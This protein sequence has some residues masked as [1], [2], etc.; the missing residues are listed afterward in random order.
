MKKNAKFE[1][2]FC[3]SFSQVSRYSLT[4]LLSVVFL[5]DA[6]GATS[7]S[8][9]LQIRQQMQ[10]D[11]QK[12]IDAAVEQGYTDSF[13][14][15]IAKKVSANVKIAQS[16]D[17]KPQNTNPAPS[18]AEAKIKPLWDKAHQLLKEGDQL[19]NQ[20]SAAALR[21]AITKF[22]EALKIW[23]LPEVRAAKPQEAPFGEAV[24]LSLIGSTYTTLTENT[25]AVGYLEQAL[26]IV[27][28]S[29]QS[30]AREWKALIL[31]SLGIVY[32]QLGEKQKAI[33]A[34]NQAQ[35]LYHA[36]KQPKKE[37]DVL[38]SIAVVYK[39]FG[40]PK[41]ERDFLERAL[42][43]QKANDDLPGQAKTLGSIAV[44]YDL[45]GETNK[46]LDYYQQ[47]LKIYSQTK[48][49]FGQAETFANI[50][51]AYSFRG[52]RSSAEKYF[53]QALELQKTN[54][55][56]IEQDTTNPF[57]RINFF[58][59]Q[60]SILSSIATGYSTLGDIQQQ[61][62]YLNKAR[63]I[64]HQLGN[65][66][67]EANFIFRIGNKYSLLGETQ[68]A[69]ENLNQ[70]LKL[71]RDIHDYQGEAE[72]LVSI[73]SVHTKST[74]FQQ[75]LDILFNQALK[76]SKRHQNP[77]L[78]SKTLYEIAKVYKNLGAYDLSIDKYKEVLKIYQQSIPSFI[79]TGFYGIGTV[80]LELCLYQKKA[81][82]CHQALKYFEDT[83][84]YAGEGYFTKNYILFSTAKA[85]ELLKE[86]PKAIAKAKQALELSRK[87]NIKEAESYALRALSTAYEGAGDYQNAL[88]TNKQHLLVSQ[89]LGDVSSQA[90]AYQIRGKIYI[91]MKQPQQAIEAYNQEL[92][93]R[94]KT[95]E[96]YHQTHSLYKI[97]IIEGD[98]GN[99]NQAKTHIE[100][101][102]N[103]IENTRSK[104][105]SDDLR[106]SY[107]AL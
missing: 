86:Y 25:K 50:G 39:V 65:F 89:Q 77:I 73:A 49:L 14:K 82:D 72:T 48:N 58:N 3:C 63:T 67:M 90:T 46:A 74:E 93:L 84:K 106:S 83:L 96:I 105:N 70:A 36:D 94:Q 37:A 53:Q 21:Q 52:D 102:I 62:V 51:L 26:A 6:V 107:F 60:M 33:D 78:E 17:A 76:I 15:K 32:Q 43:I 98:R 56:Q 13:S 92:K 10:A 101:V 27:Q 81:E 24:T 64:A 22:E 54:A 23:R 87:K 4:V 29:Q 68:K 104:V 100:T 30:E 34:Y 18:E 61:I 45:L 47:V 11:S 103:I 16:P 99:L 35:S 44:N 12:S 71:Q 42:A 57:G 55:R 19:R 88:D 31:K 80:Y 40:E 79:A 95:G 2:N 59:N 97:A 20:P 66:Q 1:C 69:L 85:Y 7:I 9:W 91:S 75:A 28:E 41:K 5:S 8:R 38:W